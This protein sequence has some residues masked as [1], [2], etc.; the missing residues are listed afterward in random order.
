[1]QAYYAFKSS[2]QGD[3]L[4]NLEG[5]RLSIVDGQGKVTVDG[6]EK[7]YRPG[8]FLKINRGQKHQVLSIDPEVALKIIVKCA[9]AWIFSDQHAV[10]N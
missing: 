9:P 3:V 1:M 4:V 2:T 7:I 10:T 5:N 8:E 6:I